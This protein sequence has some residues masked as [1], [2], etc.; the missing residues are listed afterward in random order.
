LAPGWDIVASQ[1][2]WQRLRRRDG[3]LVS[4]TSLRR[5]L[6]WLLATSLL[7]GGLV[8][9]AAV[10]GL[11]VRHPVTA[12]VLAALALISYLF[13]RRWSL[14]RV[15]LESDLPIWFVTVLWCGAPCALGIV[16][17]PELLRP[18]LD[19]PGTRP[20]PIALV[21]NLASFAW[22]VLAGTLVL[23]ALPGAH[24]GEIAAR[25]PAY[26][27]AG[28]AMVAANGLLSPGVVHC[29][30]DARRFPV[31]VVAATL[32]F[33]PLAAA[34]ACLFMLWGL[35]ALGAFAAIACLPGP[36]VHLAAPL[37]APRAGTLDRERTAHR[38]AEALGASLGLSA[39]D[40]RAIRIALGSPP[41]GHRLLPTTPSLPALFDAAGLRLAVELHRRAPEMRL[42]RAAGVLELAQAWAALTAA[43][44]LELSHP[45]ALARL[46][47]EGGRPSELLQAAWRLVDEQP[48]P[49]RRQSRAPSARALA[50]RLLALAASPHT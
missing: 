1:V 39:A 11:R 50:R 19:R 18:L 31:W 12:A 20:R 25:W 14:P 16:A 48:V 46:E 6:A 45:A 7:V 36:L 21:A 34:I 30:H 40:R 28:G 49:A 29:L 22:A 24:A 15:R 4:I 3:R 37:L 43:G 17:L 13:D 44:T 32:A 47:A 42:S 8:A 9:L 38:Y 26:A 41:R 2:A 23:H 27:A 35:P 10:D 33:V 5:S